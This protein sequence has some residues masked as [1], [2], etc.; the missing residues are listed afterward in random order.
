MKHLKILLDTN[1][2]AFLIRGRRPLV[3]QRMA[4]YLPGEVGIS[5]ITLAELE[6]GVQRSRDKSKNQAAL[7]QFT[8]LLVILPFEARDVPSYGIVRADL[9]SRGLTIGPMDTLIASHAVSRGLKVATNNLKEFSRVP[10]LDVEDW[11]Q[12]G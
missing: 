4:Q 8:K 10:N 5:I 9:Q 6:Y 11:T 7:A 2:C 1:I 3:R 12:E